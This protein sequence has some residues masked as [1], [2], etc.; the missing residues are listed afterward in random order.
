M[1]SSDVFPS[2]YCEWRFTYNSDV[3]Q[4]QNFAEFTSIVMQNCDDLSVTTQNFIEARRFLEA[5]ETSNEIQATSIRSIDQ[6]QVLLSFP[7]IFFTIFSGQI[8]SSRTVTSCSTSIC[9]FLHLF[10]NL[11]EMYLFVVYMLFSMELIVTSYGIFMS[12]STAV[13]VSIVTHCK[14]T[15]DY[16]T[17]S[18][19]KRIQEGVTGSHEE[20]INWVPSDFA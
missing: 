15:P 6:R 17:T 16:R 14:C 19:V 10:A 2:F 20:R 1:V 3:L 4:H 5:T 13:I 12:G 18:R 7:A 11:S 8:R 9:K